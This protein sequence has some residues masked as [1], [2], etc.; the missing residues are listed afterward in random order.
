MWRFILGWKT[1]GHARR[2]GAEIVNYAD[3]FVICGQVP[4][5]AMRAVVERM[6]ERLR[7]PL[8]A[9]KTRCLRVLEELVD[10]RHRTRTTP[11]ETLTAG[12]VSPVVLERAQ[13]GTGLAARPKCGIVPRARR[14]ASEPRRLSSAAAGHQPAHSTATRTRRKPPT[15]S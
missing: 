14:S 3:D 9:T 1:L 7:L 8:N 2:F 15:R 4:A 10:S 11:G 13:Q 5:P 12:H 6:M